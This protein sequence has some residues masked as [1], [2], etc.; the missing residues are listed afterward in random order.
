MT[1]TAEF[2]QREQKRALLEELR[3]AAVREASATD[4]KA[5]VAEMKVFDPTSETYFGF[6]MFQKEEDQLWL[7]FHGDTERPHYNEGWLWQAEIM[8]WWQDPKMKKYL[9]LKARQLGITWLAMARAVWLLL[10]RPGTRTVCYSYTEDEAKK[11]V[12]RAWD[13]FQSLPPS[14]RDHVNVV[15]PKRSNIPAEWIIVEHAD[16]RRSSIQA[17]PATK[18]HGHGETIT[19]GVM[20]E[21]ARMDYAREI[22]TALKPATARGQAKLCLI[23]TANGVSNQETGEG[24]FFHHVYATKEQKGFGFFFLP[25]NLEPTRDDDWYQ[26]HAMALDEVER[27]QQYPKNENDAFMLSGMAF[28]NSDALAW[29]RENT[30][31][32]KYAGQFEQKGRVADF[33]EMRDRPSL[34]LYT[35]PQVGRKYVIGA[36]TATGRGTD[37]TVA[38]VLDIE[39]AEVCAVFRAKIESPAAAIQLH[40]LGAFYNKAKIGVE[41]QGGY[42]EALITFLRE[43]KRNLPPYSN[44]YRH[45]KAT[46]GKRPIAEE[47]GMPMGSQ[48]RLTVL[49]NLK[50]MIRM[51]QFP[52][53]PA[54]LNDELGTFVYKD[55]IPSPRAEDGCNDDCVMALAI[56]A[57]LFRQY[58]SHAVSSKTRWKKAPYKPPPTR[59]AT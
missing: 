8:D 53:M 25:W 21:V 42:G 4:P 19:W 38:V 46:H 24:N 50:N 44:L 36:D 23:S 6:T 15:F 59:S 58:G 33:R 9:I 1:A 7:P 48:N 39:T 26:E 16:G 56:A 18:R 12:V 17:L 51:R 31:K 49:D 2:A 14:L 57:D 30:K 20:D 35:L 54:M 34:F 3:L 37:Y 52:L 32:A 43:G 40:F 28:F 29:Y 5:L 41:R 47:Y 45:A 13:M 22:Y 27:N 55:T 10:Y 11:L